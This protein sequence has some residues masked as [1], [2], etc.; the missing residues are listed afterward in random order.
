MAS[1]NF[2]N[3]ISDKVTLSYPMKFELSFYYVSAD[4]RFSLLKYKLY[5]E[6]WNF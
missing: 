4:E 1:L 3:C 6:V 5:M 2:S